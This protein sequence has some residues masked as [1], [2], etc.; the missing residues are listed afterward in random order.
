MK[1]TDFTINPLESEETFRQRIWTQRD[2]A[3]SFQEIKTY[4][5]KTYLLRE[6]HNAE[7][8]IHIKELLQRIIMNTKL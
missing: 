1:I 6:L 5:A 4:A 3:W 2:P 7:S 8:I